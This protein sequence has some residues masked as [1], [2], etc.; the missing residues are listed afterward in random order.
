MAFARKSPVGNS[1]SLM[2]TH[3]ISTFPREN[4]PLVVG[5]VHSKSALEEATT[6]SPG[7]VD[8]LEIRV[9]HFLSDPD[10]LLASASQL[11]FPKIVTVRRGDE[12]GASLELDD[13]TR[14]RL[15]EQFLPIADWID[16]ELASSKNL[17]ETLRTAEARNV[18]VIISNHHFD[19]TPPLEL[20][21]DD[22]ERARGA[23]ANIVKIAALTAEKGDLTR[24]LELFSSSGVAMSVMGMGRYG[25]LSRLLFATLGSRL[26]YGYLG[27]AQ[28][29][30]QWPA[31]L[32][33]QRL[34]EL[35]V[36]F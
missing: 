18:G 12:G 10:S 23:G 15:F 28:V 27:E 33:K 35:A 2:I 6:L 16:V 34:A 3:A 31:R 21:K 29:S 36:D 19:R 22:L 14:S 8:C 11:P 20:L 4:Q 30:G 7:D 1:P 13:R 9:D 32:L 5:T 24:L 26:N 17:P 25:K